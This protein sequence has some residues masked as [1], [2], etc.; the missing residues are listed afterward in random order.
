MLVKSRPIN[1]WLIISVI[2]FLAYFTPLLAQL[3]FLHVSVKS[4]V[5]L[6]VLVFTLLAG[7]A[8]GLVGLA[9]GNCGRVFMI[10][11]LSFFFFDGVFGFRSFVIHEEFY[12]PFGV[13][14]EEHSLFYFTL[15][16]AFLLISTII[17]YIRETAFQIFGAFILV[18]FLSLIFGEMWDFNTVEGKTKG[19]EEP[20]DFTEPII[21]H[22]VFDGM[23]A[24]DGLPPDIMGSQS[25][26]QLIKQFHDLFGFTLYTK[27]YSTSFSTTI[28]LA[29]LFNYSLGQ[30][31]SQAFVENNVL[32]INRHFDYLASKGYKIRIYQRDWPDFCQHKAVSYCFK[33]SS[34]ANLGVLN[35]LR[36]SVH[37]VLRPF[38]SLSLV[39]HPRSIFHRPKFIFH[40]RGNIVQPLEALL[41]LPEIFENARHAPHGTVI[42]AHL[43]IPHTPYAVDKVCKT[44]DGPPKYA[45][46]NEGDGKRNSSNTRIK[47]Y[48]AYIGQ[49]TCLFSELKRIFEDPIYSS[50]L[51]RSTIIIHGDHGS[52]VTIGDPEV[53]KSLSIRD[54]IDLFAT[55]FSI[56]RPGSPPKVDNRVLSIHQLFYETFD[57]PFPPWEKDNSSVRHEPP[58]STFISHF[59]KQ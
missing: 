27:S 32:T 29:R 20:K 23:M 35:R 54:S 25:L 7:F 14:T 18:T 28:S 53:L 10:A 48:E 55:H 40:D 47:A 44:I 15:L 30:T 26:Q 34:R 5:F 1:R 17:W 59:Q 39:S 58:L 38:L 45:F 43:I 11:W 42:F 12:S 4:Q 3:F 56:R 19:I 13:F 51:K 57:P 22:L 9:F 31:P 50:L 37:P 52:R 8:T 21:I 36:S 2:S 6:E 41:A 16:M 33:F 24:V 49:A 46:R